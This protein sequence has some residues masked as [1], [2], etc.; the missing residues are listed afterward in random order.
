MGQDEFG[1]LIEALELRG[2]D[3]A[4]SDGVRL[5]PLH[6]AVSL[7]TAVRLRHDAFGATGID[8]NRDDGGSA[9]LR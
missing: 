2:F 8:W 9:V 3:V 7:E 4:T 1:A 5:T 6:D